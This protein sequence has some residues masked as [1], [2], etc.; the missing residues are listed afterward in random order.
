MKVDVKVKG[1]KG[2][3]WPETAWRLVTGPAA[4]SPPRTETRANDFMV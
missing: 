3:G 4:A 2:M 1:P